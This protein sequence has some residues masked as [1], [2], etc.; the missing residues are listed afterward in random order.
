MSRPYPAVPAPIALF[1]VLAGTFDP[2]AGVPVLK[3]GTGIENQRYIVA[4]AGTWNF[5]TGASAGGPPLNAGDEVIYIAGVWNPIARGATGDYLRRDGSLPMTGPLDTAGSPILLRQGLIQGTSDA[6]RA[7]VRYVELVGGSWANRTALLQ[8][9]TRV[10]GNPATV[11]LLPGELAADL[12]QAAPPLLIGI[13]G[14]GDSAVLVGPARQV[15]LGAVDQVAAGTKTFRGLSFGG[16]GV[17]AHLPAGRGAVGQALIQQAGGNVSWGS[18]QLSADVQSIALTGGSS[19]TAAFNASGPHVIGQ[20]SLVFIT[21]S[22]ALYVWGGGPGTF[23]L[24]ATQATS[25]D[26]EGPILSFAGVAFATLGEVQEATVTGKAID[27]AVGGA[28][29]VVKA[30]ADQS[31][32]SNLIFSGQ[33]AIQ[34][35]WRMLTGATLN[36]EA[37][38]KLTVQDA[39][40]AGA[41]GLKDAVNRSSLDNRFQPSSGALGAPVAGLAPILDTA[42][43]LNRGLLPFQ[44][45]VDYQGSWNPAAPGTKLLRN[46]AGGGCTPPAAPGVLLYVAADGRWNFT[47]GAADPSGTQVLA[48]SLLLLDGGNTWFAATTPGGGGTG[49]GGGGTSAAALPRD[50]SLPMTGNLTFASGGLRLAGFSPNAPLA[51]ENVTIDGG[52]Y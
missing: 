3:N 12:T 35:A 46:V 10:A 14:A 43:L 7:V 17:E 5:V 20:S 28:G 1:D 9:R 6:A 48:G 32:F 52:T 11:P 21:W 15:E 49:G 13:N 31:I 27:P 8:I 4:K 22:E 34:A 42:G 19:I 30:G 36:V 2:V 38:A 41:P 39:P 40:R 25:D 45:P 44:T 16:A 47:T 51:V 24:G 37:G 29:Y 18:V 26:F 23:G 33:V 50:G